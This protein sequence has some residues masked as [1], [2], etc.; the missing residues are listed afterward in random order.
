MAGSGCVGRAIEKNEQEENSWNI[1]HRSYSPL[2]LRF[3]RERFQVG[4]ALFHC[5]RLH[6]RR[7]AGE[8]LREDARS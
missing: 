1:L 4:D 7:D 6:L 5:S 8:H 2:Q 3:R